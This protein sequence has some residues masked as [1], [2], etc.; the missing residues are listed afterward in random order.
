MTDIT[1][2]SSKPFSFIAHAAHLYDVSDVLDEGR[3]AY[4]AAANC[5][6]NLDREKAVKAAVF[7]YTYRPLFDAAILDAVELN[8]TNYQLDKLVAL[9]DKLFLAYASG[10]KIDELLHRMQ[11]LLNRY[12][13]DK[14]PIWYCWYLIR[15]E[16]LYTYDGD[17]VPG[18]PNA[19]VEAAITK[20]HAKL[21]ENK[22]K[23]NMSEDKRLGETIVRVNKLEKAVDAMATGVADV[24]KMLGQV[25]QM[26]QNLQAPATQIATPA[27]PAITTPATG[28]APNTPQVQITSQA[29]QTSTA[30][31]T[32]SKPKTRQEREAEEYQNAVEDFS[33]KYFT[34]GNFD[35]IG[36]LQC[37]KATLETGNVNPEK[38]LQ[39]AIASYC[40]A[41][42]KADMA[43]IF[44]LVFWAKS[45]HG[46]VAEAIREIGIS[47]L[48]PELT[49]T[50]LAYI[51]KDRAGAFEGS[52]AFRE[53]PSERVK[54]VGMA[55]MGW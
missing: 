25:Q 3:V 1:L 42:P 39:T 46:V 32:I 9:L 50:V 52:K 34:P 12:Y 38:L 11:R 35:I 20:R 27:V 43:Q 37:V 51:E 22:E 55:L 16:L 44:K 2:D 19:S 36:A 29:V 7:I 26:L 31:I 54:A 45:Q 14:L 18:T 8:V 15:H 6:A 30:P 4:F 17:F 49:R 33:A 21:T 24:Q 40:K 41:N 10:E 23:N 53:H 48:E 5:P 13:V 47:G 28:Q